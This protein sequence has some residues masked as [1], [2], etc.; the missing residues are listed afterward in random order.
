MPA[1]AWMTAEGALGI[2]AGIGAGS[3]ALIGWVLSSVVEGTASVIVIWRFTGSRTSH[4]IVRTSRESAS[5]I[6][7]LLPRCRRGQ[8][9]RAGC[10]GVR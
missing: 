4:V 1:A 10:R 8:Q 2:L 6:A 7:G 5:V 3:I 9:Q